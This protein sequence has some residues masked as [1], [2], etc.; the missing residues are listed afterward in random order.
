MFWNR[1]K[2]RVV[3]QESAPVWVEV[4]APFS[5]RALTLA[6][7]PDPVFAQKMVGDGAAVDPASDTLVAPVSGT[8]TNLFPTGHAAGITT[9]EGL[10]I[11]IH[12]GM[13]TVELKG[14]GFTPVARQGDR[15]TAGQPII[16]MD[17]ERL[18]SVAKSLVTPV[19]LTNPARV[20]ALEPVASGDVVA[21]RD[22]LFRVQVR[23]EADER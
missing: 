5:G 9:D 1:R 3:E 4:L 6:D 8:L 10:E 21:G 18:R 13:D 2:T 12:I 17:L 15:V 16:R 7:V 23:R 19:V 20:A 14:E 22:V 11:L